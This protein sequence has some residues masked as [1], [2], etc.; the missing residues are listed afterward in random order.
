MTHMSEEAILSGRSLW[1]KHLLNEIPEF[2]DAYRGFLDECDDELLSH[3]M[4]ADVLLPYLLTRFRS[5]TTS[6]NERHRRLRHRAKGKQ[7]AESDE[8]AARNAKLVLKILT[9]LEEGLAHGDHYLR[10]VILISFL[11][12]LARKLHP[13][14]LAS[15]RRVFGPNL[16][17]GLGA[18]ERFISQPH[19]S[20]PETEFEFLHWEPIQQPRDPS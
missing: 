3:L 8:A 17:S 18:A 6:G 13:D 16:Q 10:E 2:H 19:R 9:C 7:T 4:M 12:E 11:E 5:S 20:N 15:L 1:E 14:E